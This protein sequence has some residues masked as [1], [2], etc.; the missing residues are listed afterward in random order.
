MSLNDRQP[1][2]GFG[3]V[4]VEQVAKRYLKRNVAIDES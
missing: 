4:A 1:A 2:E 3:D